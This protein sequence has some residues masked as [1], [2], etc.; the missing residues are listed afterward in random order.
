M[1]TQHIL[2]TVHFLEALRTQSEETEHLAPVHK[3]FT[4]LLEKQ[5]L[6]AILQNIYNDEAE[7]EHPN[8]TE[9]T[10]EELLAIIKD[11][12]YIL[13]YLIEEVWGSYVL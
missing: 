2:I 10:K 3:A 13:E 7:F 8:F 4:H 5:E 11:E 1:K 12:Y 6:V 9:K